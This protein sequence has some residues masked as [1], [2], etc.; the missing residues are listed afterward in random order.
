MKVLQPK[1]IKINKRRRIESSDKNNLK[2]TL[3]N[4]A[5]FLKKYS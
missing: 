4:D 1:K 2:K 5:D 3:N